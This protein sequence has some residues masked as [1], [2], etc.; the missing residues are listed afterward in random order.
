MVFVG[1][2]IKGLYFVWGKVEVNF[3]QVSTLIVS[4]LLARILTGIIF[5]PFLFKQIAL[6]VVVI[7]GLSKL[8]PSAPSCITSS[9]NPDY[10]IYSAS[11]SIGLEK[12]S[13]ISTI[14]NFES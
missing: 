5:A 1:V 8:F 10:C 7:I 12:Y 14:R 9:T 13:A 3:N 2:L 6:G 4:R 11:F